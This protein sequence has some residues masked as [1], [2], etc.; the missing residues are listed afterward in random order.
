[1]TGE[2]RSIIRF[3][4]YKKSGG[5]HSVYDDV[6]IWEAAR[7]TSAA[8]SFFDPITITSRNLP[9]MFSDGSLGSNNP[10]YELW[11]EAGEVW[12]RPG[13]PLEPQIRCLLSVGT[14]RP[15]LEILGRSLKEVGQTIIDIAT[16]TQE[17]AQRFQNDREELFTQNR[18][19]RFNPLDI[20][21]VGLEEA[22]QKALI[23]VRTETYVNDPDTKGRINCFKEVVGEE[24][25]ASTQATLERMQYA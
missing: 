10:V 21:E 9:R 24:Q 7:A 14:G 20:S 17:T 2:A 3:T 13:L 16:E 11:Q 22:K 18:A 5:E 1:M 15:R 4:D 19:F 6:K 23:A 12:Q 25:S 8:T